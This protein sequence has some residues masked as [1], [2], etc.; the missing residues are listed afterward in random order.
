MREEGLDDRV[1]DLDTHF[2]A[3]A[4]T[5]ITFNVEGGRVAPT[6]T[7]TSPTAGKNRRVLTYL[8]I[9]C[10]TIYCFRILSYYSYK[11]HLS[12]EASEASEASKP[13]PC[14]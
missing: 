14:P 3:A 11:P 4:L 9:K 5:G 6:S 2:E 10:R 1:P 13:R 7:S 12:G 8:M